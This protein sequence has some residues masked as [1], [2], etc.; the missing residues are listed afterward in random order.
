YR[1]VPTFGRATIRRFT[2]NASAMK[3]LAARNFEDL[4]QCA[5]PVFEGLLADEHNKVILDLLFLLAFWHALAKLRMHTTFSLE[6]L[7]DVTSSLGRQLRYFAKYTRTKFKTKEL[8][9][10]EAARGRRQAKKA[11]AAA[12]RSGVS[13]PPTS[14]SKPGGGSKS[15]SKMKWFNLSTYK[16]HALGDY[17]PTIRF[18]GTSDS[19]STQTVR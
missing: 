19:Y 9:S 17:V 7:D 18:F 15:D 4:L 2:D 3:K 14:A 8:P 13:E 6:R 16:A 12:K 5:I 10:E 11:A 1:M